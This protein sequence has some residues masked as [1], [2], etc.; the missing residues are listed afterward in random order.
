MEEE[1]TKL[2]KV[3]EG[4]LKGREQKT[5]AGC[6]YYSFQGVPY[7]RPPLGLLRFKVRIHVLLV[8]TS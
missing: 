3:T 6:V 8:T 1:F 5:A 7:A 2:V 4:T